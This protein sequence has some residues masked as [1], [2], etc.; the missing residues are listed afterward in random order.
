[1]TLE[2]QFECNC[3]NTKHGDVVICPNELKKEQ[4]MLIMEKVERET[5]REFDTGAT[6]DTDLNKLDYEGFLSPLVIKRYA[7]YLNEYRTQSDG[8]IRDSDN[9]QKGIP[10]KVYM[11]SK[12]RHFMD[13]WMIFR[14]YGPV[15]DIKDNHI[16]TM[17]EALCGEIFNAS[18]HLHELLKEKLEPRKPQAKASLDCSETMREDGRDED[19]HWPDYS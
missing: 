3:R 10:I 6:R 8:N 19:G 17:E 1:M 16:I 12:W 2:E 4:A 13:T 14:G 7:E 15:H 9:W 5:M 11:K 18:G